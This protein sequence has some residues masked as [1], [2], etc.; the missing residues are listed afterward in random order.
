MRDLHQTLLT[1]STNG[2]GVA[3]TLLHGE[4]GQHDGGDAK[5]VPVLFK[6]P[7]EVGARLEW[8]VPFLKSSVGGF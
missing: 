3:T 7:N 5:L 1:A 8:T 6:D 4:G 2:V